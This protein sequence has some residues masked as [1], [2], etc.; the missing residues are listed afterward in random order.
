MPKPIPP[1]VYALTWER[2][3]ETE[4]ASKVVKHANSLYKAIYI[5]IGSYIQSHNSLSQLHSFGIF[6]FDI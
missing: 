4:S 6:L 3:L 1:L 2:N 5:D